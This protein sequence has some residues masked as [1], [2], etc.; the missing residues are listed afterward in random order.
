MPL[1]VLQM[2][3]IGI[4]GNPDDLEWKQ[5]LSTL[6]N[7]RLRPP[8]DIECVL[9]D[10]WVLL[11]PSIWHEAFGM[12]VIEGLAR[13]LPVLSS[14]AGGLPEAKLGTSHILPVN[15][16]HMG[17]HAEDQMEPTVTALDQ[18]NCTP[19]EGGRSIADATKY[20]S[21]H[22]WNSGTVLQRNLNWADRVIP[23]QSI[24]PWASAL[25]KVLSRESYRMESVLSRNNALEHISLGPKLLQAF[26]QSLHDLVDSHN[27]D[28]EQ[29]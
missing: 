20:D 3:F 21:R 7:V 18:N 17:D 25:Q 2:S 29:M 13:G 28:I 24:T 22:R 12:V 6:C 4:T 5:K 15:T 23:P 26:V 10:A 11:C 14:N 1:Y 19:K 9:A 8:G 16:I 27:D